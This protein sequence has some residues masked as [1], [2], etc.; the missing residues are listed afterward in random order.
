VEI[1]YNAQVDFMVNDVNKLVRYIVR[2]AK[3]RHYVIR[4]R[5]VTLIK[6]V[7]NNVVTVRIILHVILK[8]VIVNNV[9]MGSMDASA[10]FTNALFI[11]LTYHVIQRAGCVTMAAEMVIGE[12]IARI[13]VHVIA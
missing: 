8:Q 3:T 11:V 2:N 12:S 6:I 1:V 10:R 13:F 4:A 9:Q 7:P 5:M